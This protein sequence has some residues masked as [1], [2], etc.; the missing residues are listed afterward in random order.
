MATPVQMPALSPT[1]TEGKITR[2][3]KK[4][5]EKVA[6]GEA[7]AEVET[8]KA[9]LEVEAFEDGYLLQIGVQEG[10]SAEVGAPIAFIGAQ[11]E[12]PPA[13]AP[14]SKP[15]PKAPE[16][17]QA[18]PAEAPKPQ[19][20]GKPQPSAAKPVQ[21]PALSPTMTSGKISRWLKREGDEV[22]SGEAIAEVET[23]KA[24]LELE[25]FEEGVLLQIAVKEGESA[26]VG[27]PVA[28]VGP[29]GAKVGEQPKAGEKKAQEPAPTPKASPPRGT[30][31]GQVVPLRR[32][33]GGGEKAGRVRASP[34]ARRMAHERNLD[35]REVAGSGPRGRVVKR[36]IEQA[37]R[38]GAQA[39]TGAAPRK[40]AGAP[41]ERGKAQ[42]LPL[43]SIRKVIAQRMTE[44]K[45][46]VPHFYLTV[47]VEMDAAM[48]IREEAKALEA[49]V[50]VNDILIKAAA[51]AL[52]RFPQVNV[53]FGGD[54]LVQHATAD[55]A[56]AVALEEGLITPVVRDA[57]QK[58]LSAIAAEARELAERARK[59]A[60]K[61]EEYTGGSI[62]LSNLGMYGIDSFVAVINPPH[63]AILAVGAVADKPVVRDGELTVRKMMSVTLSGDHRAIDGA[64]GAQYLRELQQLL[65]HP[66]RLIF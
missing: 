52:R 15:A 42:K 25:S 19:A 30:G 40:A 8:D 28:Y 1:M 3:L 17:K 58:G 2:W 23:D 10:E 22:K 5:G 38:G 64:L 47:E 27:A 13:D 53:S 20:A 44:A 32:E 29:K 60:L 61:P 56:F 9:N 6:S 34:L 66:L 49:K 14:S 62:A 57:D 18:R 59:R 12:Q 33:G 36:D 26:E 45:P 31:N 63:A 16:P 51:V 35:L 48:A 37:L 55:V 46:G 21:M 54:H 65:E 50:S 24:N 4:V 43:S 41:L 39:P 7:I 11:G